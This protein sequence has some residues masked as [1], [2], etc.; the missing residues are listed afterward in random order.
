MSSISSS[1][2]SSFSFSGS[3]SIGSPLS[4]QRNIGSLDDLYW[5]TNLINDVKLY[6][7]L[8]ICDSIVFKKAINDEK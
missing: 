3:L 6:C 7:H 4:P 5:V 1:S 8:V 2:S